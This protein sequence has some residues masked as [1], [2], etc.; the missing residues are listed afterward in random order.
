MR[1]N[2]LKYALLASIVATG[3]GSV[4]AQSADPAR[5]VMLGTG[6]PNADPERSGPS[7]AVVYA[8]KSYLVDAGPGLVRRAATAAARLDL[9]ELQAQSLGIAFITH[10][11]SDHT[12]GLPDLI[13]TSWVAERRAPF[14]LFGPPG[15]RRMANHLT[16]AWAED[17]R[18]RTRGPQPST[19]DG[20]KIDTREVSDGIVYRDGDLTVR[21]FPVPHSNWPSA[22]G[23]R[24]DAGG[25]S[26]VISGDTRASDAVVNACNGCDVL[27]HEVYSSEAYQKIPPEWQR[28]HAGSHT[29]T[30]E[31]AALATRARPGLLVMYHQLYW[32]AS[33][34]DL[35][36]EIR[37]AGYTGRVVAARDLEV[38]P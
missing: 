15:I 21:A 25:R 28:Y 13:H 37:A 38:Y 9:P 17:I 2:P 27:V 5:V 10:L 36:R 8:G 22:L 24:F 14:Q 16:E 6:T 33:D 20:W 30:I 18:I 12:V 1:G 29:S 19:P 35:L 31:L 26:I 34:D 3:G 11:H 7:V 32:G 23:Y 4:A